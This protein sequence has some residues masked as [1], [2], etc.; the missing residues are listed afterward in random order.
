LKQVRVD[1]KTLPISIIMV[2]YNGK[3]DL[4]KCFPTLFATAYSD[5]EVILIDNGSTDQ[6]IAYLKKWAN[7]HRNLT[8]V[9]AK[10][11]L[12]FAPANN[13]GLEYAKG[14]II[15]LLNCDTIVTTDWLQNLV[16]PLV[17]DPSV[18]IVQSKLLT[19]SNPNIIDSA[20]DIVHPSG[21]SISRGMGEKDS[22]Q[23]DHEKEIFSARGAAIAFR[24]S[25]ATKIGLFDSSYFMTYED[26]DF[27]WRTRMA[28]YKVIYVPNSVVYHRGFDGYNK[29][30]L[31][32]IF[33][34]NKNH[35][36]TLIKNYEIENVIHYVLEFATLNIVKIATAIIMPKDPQAKNTPLMFRLNL[37]LAII[38]APLYVVKNFLTVWEK[39][40]K[41]QQGRKVNDKAIIAAMSK[42]PL[43][44]FMFDMRSGSYRKAT[45]HIKTS[46]SQL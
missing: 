9:E 37:V 36:M 23:F 26:V 5:F 21:A 2:N 45:E 28:G 6:S 42:A 20:G 15:V 10:K 27:C 40:F 43:G 39:R 13:I 7:D 31:M 17:D 8:V 38:K 1:N 25:L 22:G 30:Y 41:I 14:A 3:A 34:N 18:G 4:E 29:T 44:R 11:N 12:G 46:Q 16:Q 19:L 32:K 24:K 35:Y 33:H